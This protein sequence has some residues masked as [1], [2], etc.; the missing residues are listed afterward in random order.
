VIDWLT[1]GKPLAE[2]FR[3]TNIK[4][5]YANLS[6]PSLQLQTLNTIFTSG[7]LNYE[8]FIEEAIRKNEWADALLMG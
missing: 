3:D 6:S 7:G 2:T 8:S 1:E 4:K 5:D